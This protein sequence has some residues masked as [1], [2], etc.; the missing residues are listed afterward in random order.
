MEHRTRLRSNLTDVALR[1]GAW[2]EVRHNLREALPIV[3]SELR[4]RRQIKFSNSPRH[5]PRGMGDATRA[6]RWYGAA[7]AREHATGIKRRFHRE[8]AQVR[9]ARSREAGRSGIRTGGG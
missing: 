9:G 2:E 5:W 6:A 3:R 7:E 1:N 4:V 8:K